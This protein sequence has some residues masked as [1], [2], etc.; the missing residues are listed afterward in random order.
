MLTSLDSIVFIFFDKETLISSWYV[1][2][3]ES[4]TDNLYKKEQS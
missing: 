2:V 3:V 1:F 4:L